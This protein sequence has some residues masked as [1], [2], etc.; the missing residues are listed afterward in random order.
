MVCLNARN[1]LLLILL[2]TI[3]ISSTV[4]A[5][6]FVISGGARTLIS[7][8][9]LLIAVGVFLGAVFTLQSSGGEG[10]ERAVGTDITT[11]MISTITGLVAFLIFSTVTDV[12]LGLTL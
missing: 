4:S 2:A 10:D 1:H 3:L 9:P 6:S 11:I 8:A 12:L 5:Q 7:I